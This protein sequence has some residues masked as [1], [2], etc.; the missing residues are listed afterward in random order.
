MLL[1]RVLSHGRSDRLRSLHRQYDRRR[2][3]LDDEHVVSAE[4][5]HWIVM[6][7][8]KRSQR[9]AALVVQ[10]SD[11]DFQDRRWNPGQ[12]GEYSL[13]ARQDDCRP[14]VQAQSARAE[15]GWGAVSL[16]RSQRA[17]YCLPFAILMASACGLQHADSGAAGA[18]H[19]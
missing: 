1:V 9:I 8:P 10:G 18:V 12:I 7:D 3:P 17:T 11:E 13:R 6:S 14:N 2:K 5:G 16:V 15:I 4:A 19:T